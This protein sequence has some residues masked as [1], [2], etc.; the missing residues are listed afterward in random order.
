MF[1]EQSEELAFFSFALP[2]KKIISEFR[3]EV[4]TSIRIS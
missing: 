2:H 1:D 3:R 4:E